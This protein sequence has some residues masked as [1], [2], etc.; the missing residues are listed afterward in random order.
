MGAAVPAGALAKASAWLVHA[1]T[2]SGLVLALLATRAAIDHDYRG[3]FFWLTLQVFVDASDGVLARLARV[4]TVL[5]WF[6]GATLDNITD[7]LAYVF[8]PALI[9]WR[10]VLVPDAWSL[11]VAAAMLLSSAFGFS[12]DDAKTSDHFFTGFPS[13]WNVVVLYLYVAGLPSGVNATIL[14]ALVGMV[15]V[16]IRY[17]YPSRMPVLRGLTVTLGAIWGAL[18]LAMIWQMPAVSRPLLW[19]TLVFPAYYAALSFHLSAKRP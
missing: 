18:I 12:R 6:N 16:P 2:A 15:F 5:P 3:A 4:S 13:Y 1:Y 9:V 19:G 11:P 7:Y 17:V 8:V 10:A 14:V